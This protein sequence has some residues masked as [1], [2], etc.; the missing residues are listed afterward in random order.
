MDKTALSEKL[1]KRVV[2]ASAIVVGLLATI[3]LLSWRFDFWRLAA[4]G[5]DY[6]PM[7]PSTAWLLL[8]LSGALFLGRRRP[9]LPTTLGFAILALSCTV[10]VTI[11]VIGRTLLEFELPLEQWLAPTSAQVGDI[12][13][14]RMSPLTAGVFLSISLALL[15]QL[16]RFGQRWLWRQTSALCALLTLLTGLA[17]LLSYWAGAPLLYN[18]RTIP[19]ALPTAI[20]FSLLGSGVLFNAGSDTWPIA[21][22]A[23]RTSNPP[24]TLLHRFAKGPLA[25]FLVLSLA[26]ATVGGLLLKKQITHSRQESQQVLATISELKSAQIASWYTERQDDAELIFHNSLIQLQL[27][28]YLTG[29]RSS[30]QT[31]EIREWLSHLQQK[32]FRRLVLFDATGKPLLRAPA[33]MPLSG[34]DHRSELQRILSADTVLIT[35]LHQEAGGPDT[36]PPEINL[37]V[38]IPMGARPGSGTPAKGAL[39]LQIDPRNFLYPLIQTWPTRSSTAETLLVRKEGREVVYLN[40]LKHR[41]GTAFSLRFPIDSKYLPA[42]LAARGQTGV[43]EGLDYRNTPVLAALCA[44]PGTPWF[45]VAKVDQEEVYAPLRLQ[46]WKT[47]SMILALILATALGVS[48]LWQQYDNQLLR[49]ELAL[50][51]ERGRMEEELRRMNEELETRVLERT[52]QFQDANQELEAFAYSV[53]HDLRAPLRAMGGFSQALLEDFGDKLEGEARAYLDEIVLGSRQM[54]Q[55]IDGLLTLSRST[56]GELRSDRVNLSE[57]ADR[58]RSEIERSDKQRRVEWQIEPGLRARGDERMIAV[59]MRNLLDNAWKYTVGTANPIIRVYTEPEGNEHFFCVTDNGAGFDMAHTGKLFQPFQRLHRQ[60]EFPGLGIGL[61]TAQRIVHRHGG[62]IHA[63]GAPRQGA[64]FSFSL[65]FG[66]DLK[67]EKP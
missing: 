59:V 54:A 35:D 32:G 38:W 30:P 17:V 43:M 3:A 13:A 55:L 12:P 62:K 53:S 60:D 29:S 47:G 4:L 19:M 33:N 67:G 6:I 45:M 42:A 5:N 2:E 50:V 65:P 18:G 34:H 26:I 37:N 8:L 10:L 15:C 28:N 27:R 56:R 61:A 66:E 14:G 44:I 11:V 36:G 22:F 21:L 49:R 41:S 31:D 64:T 25:A 24:P 46:A 16:P 51:Q 48:L 57:M 52:A 58:I 63:T 9:A 7:A 1:Q 39:L 23:V 40:E 20:A